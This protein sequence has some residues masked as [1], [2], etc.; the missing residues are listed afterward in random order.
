[1]PFSSR[2]EIQIQDLV[3]DIVNRAD[4]THVKHFD[5]L[6]KA[7]EAGLVE[8][9]SNVTEEK[10]PLTEEVGPVKVDLSVADDAT[11]KVNIFINNEFEDVTTEVQELLTKGFEETG[12]KYIIDDVKRLPRSRMR[13][14]FGVEAD[15]VEER[16]FQSNLPDEKEG[17][18]EENTL[19]E[20]EVEF[21]KIVKDS[22]QALIE[23]FRNMSEL[24]KQRSIDER[25]KNA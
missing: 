19:K 9:N 24:R 5:G 4:I 21:K 25:I 2:Y 6:I 13:P 8:A 23:D 1:M 10:Q 14:R 15:Y 20:A 18:Q 12:L 16:V 22:V 7:L 3:T 11:V 17:N